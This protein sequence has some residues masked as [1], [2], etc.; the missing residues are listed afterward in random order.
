M[1]KFI[2]TTK[3]LNLVLT[4]VAL[5]TSAGGVTQVVK[6]VNSYKPQV[7]EVKVMTK[8]GIEAE[9]PD[10]LENDSVDNHKP[11]N[12]KFSGTGPTQPE[13]S[14]NIV[15]TTTIKTTNKGTGTSLS[16]SS[17]S[18]ASSKTSS[19]ST[20]VSSESSREV[21]DEDKDSEKDEEEQEW[22]KQKEEMEKEFEKAKKESESS[23]HEETST[24][25]E[26]SHD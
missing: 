26:G 11:S 13:T 5:A 2:P 15:E 19:S 1:I 23:E 6:E 8:T 22:E 18:K 20:S 25:A 21:V 24:E 17:S 10:T 7:P 9:T 3:I 14:Q 4:G 12:T 16:L